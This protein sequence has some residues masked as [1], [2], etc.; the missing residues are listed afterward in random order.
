MP[1]VAKNGLGDRQVGKLT[2]AACQILHYMRAVACKFVCQSLY[3]ICT[4]SV[5]GQSQCCAVVIA[6]KTFS[7][8]IRQNVSHN[9][10]K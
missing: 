4:V 5:S 7:S 10:A 1:S 8:L 3:H 6:G 9:L 2:T